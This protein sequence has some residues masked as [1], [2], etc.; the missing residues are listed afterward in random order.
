[1]SRNSEYRERE[2]HINRPLKTDVSISGMKIILEYFIGT[3]EEHLTPQTY[4]REKFAGTGDVRS[5]CLVRGVQR[6]WL[7]DKV[8]PEQRGSNNSSDSRKGMG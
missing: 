1:M 8:A 2:I 5:K 4:V 3:K 7:D 6:P